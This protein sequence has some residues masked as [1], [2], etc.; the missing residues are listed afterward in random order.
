MNLWNGMPS[1]ARGVTGWFFSRDHAHA[2]SAYGEH[3]GLGGTETKPGCLIFQYGNQKPIIGR[4][5]LDRWQWHQVI[6]VR[7]PHRIQVFLD[8][9]S[10]PEID[11][12]LPAK[13][14]E[15]INTYFLA[16]RSDSS[17]NW[18]GSLDE[19]ALFPRALNESQRKNLSPR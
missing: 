19:V 3:L 12:E 8:G 10:E 14:T 11:A 9:K 7:E 17:N 16:G 4:T 6:I 18:Q 15:S 5:P 13:P 2:T 1:D